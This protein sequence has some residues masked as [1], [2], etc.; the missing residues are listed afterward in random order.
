VPERIYVQ[1]PA[2][3]DLELIPTV[4]D[5]LGQ[6]RNPKDL[7]V[8][9][10][11][12]FGPG[13]EGMG[14][15][16]RQLPGVQVLGITAAE[17]Q[18]CNWARQLLQERWD[19]QEYT[20]F[21]D[22]HHRFVPDWDESLLRMYRGLRESGVERPILTS[23]LPAYDPVTDP[24]GRIE[25]VYRMT[26][27]ERYWRMPFQLVGHPVRDWRRLTSPTAAGY[28]SLHMLFAEGRF[29]EQVPFD[30]GVY[31]FA[32][33]VA[34]ALR[35]YTHGYDLFH[36]HVV[37]GWHLYDRRTRTTHWADHPDWGARNQVSIERLRQ[38]FSGTL[39]DEYALG[40]VRT[41]SAYESYAQVTLLADDVPSPKGAAP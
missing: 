33:E 32:D 34:V 4:T 28:V 31:F 41:I 38:L 23:Y 10:A 37:L 9:I 16:L 2:Y 27:A 1:I 30:P 20:L 5:L 7:T 8:G 25:T 39:M 15:A 22:S 21:L 11:W 17:S 35:A 12:Q 36:P 24:A 3:R 26:V 13:E 19:G 40:T 29:N 18:G 6:A 14:Q